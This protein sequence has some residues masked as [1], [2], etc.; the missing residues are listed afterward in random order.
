M[1]ALTVIATAYAAT[2][3]VSVVGFGPG[4]G[5]N[6]NPGTFGDNS[7]LYRVQN[8]DGAEGWQVRYRSF[9]APDRQVPNTQP[10]DVDTLWV[11][12]LQVGHAFTVHT[13]ESCPCMHRYCFCTL[14]GDHWNVS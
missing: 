5:P 4:S 12:Q 10:E 9:G 2:R 1:Q 13:A 6:A 14:M 11:P 3:R 8:D 7:R